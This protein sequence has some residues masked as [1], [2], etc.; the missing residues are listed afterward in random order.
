MYSWSLPHF[1]P[2][3]WASIIPL[4]RDF[5][6]KSTTTHPSVRTTHDSFYDIPT[7]P[8]QALSIAVFGIPFLLFI[9]FSRGHWCNEFMPSFS[10]LFFSFVSLI[11]PLYRILFN[12]MVFLVL[13][14]LFS[15]LALLRLRVSLC[16][17]ISFVLDGHLSRFWW[18]EHVGFYDLMMMMLFLPRIGWNLTKLHDTCSF[19]M[20]MDKGMKRRFSR[21]HVLMRIVQCCLLIFLHSQ[22]H[23]WDGRRIL[24][25][26]YCVTGRYLGA[27][28]FFEFRTCGSLECDTLAL[29]A[30]ARFCF[31]LLWELDFGSSSLFSLCSLHTNVVSMQWERCW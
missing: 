6:P 29:C 12:G 13:F 9:Y 14:F 19:D 3:G 30:R 17:D 1:I 8:P 25:E 31:C 26:N 22:A 16:H 27:G 2:K 20:A 21:Q 11:S 15:F 24:L 10:C 7:L 18:F 23:A 5:P 4:L 28:W